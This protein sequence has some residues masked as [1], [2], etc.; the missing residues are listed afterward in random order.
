MIYTI[1][2]TNNDI[3][4]VID[5]HHSLIESQLSANETAHEGDYPLTHYTFDG[6]VFTEKVEPIT[7]PKVANKNALIMHVIN[8]LERYGI[9]LDLTRETMASKRQVKEL[10]DQAAGA[11][12]MRHVSNGL[13]VDQE[14]QQA[15][16]QAIAYLADNSVIPP[17]IQTW[18]DVSGMTLADAAQ[19]II[20]TANQWETALNTIYD[21]RLRGKKAVDDATAENFKDVA[22][23]YINQ[24]DAI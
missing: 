2:N 1:T 22:Q 21:L 11:A 19:N 3:V 6:S 15:K 10:I 20:D 9:Y 16:T 12:R 18:S 13:L 5:C 4:R 8:D 24:L 7:F 23:S 14:Y 17:M